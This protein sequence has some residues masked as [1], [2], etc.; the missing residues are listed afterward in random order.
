[1]ALP[2]GLIKSQ[3]G[4]SQAFPRVKQGAEYPPPSLLSV[5]FD[6]STAIFSKAACQNNISHPEKSRFL[7]LTHKLIPI[8]A[9]S[10]W[11]WGYKSYLIQTTWH[12]GGLA[13]TETT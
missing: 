11:L 7:A 5:Y 9:E 4:T 13:V 3:K 8:P 1:M 10:Q 6:T 2:A 12:R